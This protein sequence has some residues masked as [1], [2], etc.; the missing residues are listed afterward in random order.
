MRFTFAFVP[1]MV[2]IVWPKG[3]VQWGR[4]RRNICL[5]FFVFNPQLN[6]PLNTMDSFWRAIPHISIL[7]RHML[8]VCDFMCPNYWRQFQ[9][10]SLS[11]FYLPLHSIVSNH[12]SPWQCLHTLIRVVVQCEPY[13]HTPRLISAYMLKNYCREIFSF[14]LL[15]PEINKYYVIST[16][17]L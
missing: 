4:I 17:S 15:T 8:R 2:L 10:L 12:A 5:P 16:P 9:L 11:H 6:T 14:F 13:Q 7:C 1:L 3:F